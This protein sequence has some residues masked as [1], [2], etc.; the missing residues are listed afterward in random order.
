[1]RRSRS[2]GAGEPGR[3]EGAALQLAARRQHDVAD[4]IGALS[5]PVLVAGGRHDG[6]APLSNLEAIADA[7]PAAQLE[8]FDGGHLF[9]LQDQRAWPTI[10]EW[11]LA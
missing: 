7:V 2:V 3:A 6:I 11:L 5:M 10:V 1:M 8:V 4:R 9:L